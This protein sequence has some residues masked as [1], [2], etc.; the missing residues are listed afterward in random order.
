MHT[1][2]NGHG[3]STWRNMTLFGHTV[4][5][6]FRFFK[7]K[8][9]E[10]QIYKCVKS[11]NFYNQCKLGSWS[12][13]RIRVTLLNIKFN[14]SK[15]CDAEKCEVE[16]TMI[17]LPKQTTTNKF[18]ISLHWHTFICISICFFVYYYYYYYYYYYFINII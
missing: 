3:Y 4:N 7:L 1:T 6:F 8:L 17:Q 16:I 13:I 5:S 11:T 12:T 15:V 18:Q 14:L 10:V 9:Y 2:I